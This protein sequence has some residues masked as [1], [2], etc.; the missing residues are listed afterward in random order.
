MRWLRG[1][2]HLRAGQ[3]FGVGDGVDAAEFEDQGLAVEPGRFHFARLA[4]RGSPG[5]TET[6][7]GDPDSVPACC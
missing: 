6:L 5:R 4:G 1:D 3:R 2:A 7:P